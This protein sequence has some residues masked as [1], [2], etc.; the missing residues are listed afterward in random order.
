MNR[1]NK[2]VSTYFCVF[3]QLQKRNLD[4]KRFHIFLLQLL[5][6]TRSLTKAKVSY[7]LL[8]ARQLNIPPKVMTDEHNSECSLSKESNIFDRW[9]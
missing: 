5:P 6:Q 4:E 8:A 2:D 3:A 9:M 1:I 7:R